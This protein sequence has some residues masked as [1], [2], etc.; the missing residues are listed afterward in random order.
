MFSLSS[1]LCHGLFGS[2]S[3]SGFASVHHRLFD[4]VKEARVPQRLS[5]AHR[6]ADVAQRIDI[7]TANLVQGRRM[8]S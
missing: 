5:L 3:Q 6:H 2:A 7:G 4:A 1:L 8:V